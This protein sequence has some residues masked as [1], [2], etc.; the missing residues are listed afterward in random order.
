MKSRGLISLII[1]ISI[2]IQSAL[3]QN[4]CRTPGYKMGRCLPIYNCDYLLNILRAKP[5]T[6]QTIRFLQMSQCDAG[7]PVEENIPYVCCARNDDSLI[8]QPTTADA[9][10]QPSALLPKISTQTANFDDYE[11]EN[12]D[13]SIS[14]Q[15]STDLLPNESDCG[16]EYI[17]NRI[18]SGQNTDREEFP[19]LA[20]FEYR[21][22]SGE[23][24]INCAGSLISKKYVLT[25]SHCITGDIIARIGMLSNIRLGDY[26]LREADAC[27]ERN[28]QNPY[29]F[30]AIEEVIPHEN[31]NQ[32]AINRRNDIGLVRLR[33][34]VRFSRMVRPICL[35]AADLPPLKAGNTVY[36]VGFGRTL[37]ARRS[38]IKQKLAIP[39]YDHE[40]CKRKFSSK[41]V[42]IH[43]EQLC[44]GGEFSKDAC[45]GDSGG[46]L[47]RF[48]NTWIV[49]GIVSFGYLCGLED[50][51]AIYTKVSSYRSWI[52]DHMRP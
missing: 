12:T 33:K 29:R 9:P 30:N 3:T 18:Y 44:A 2:T 24:S 11:D 48:H 45:D 38:T 27:N 50:W 6:Q 19:W 14:F 17:E 32:R 34:A 5:L 25:A 52:E 7:W 51:P 43:D 46:P 42:V 16:R 37:A 35:P 28:C 4:F 22:F 49:E 20:L 47:Q 39:I 1:L 10:P 15:N 41:K 21:K 8:L 31:Y 23:V 26:D 13:D 40:I 36:I